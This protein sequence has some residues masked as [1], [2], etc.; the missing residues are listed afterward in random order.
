MGENIDIL[1]KHF[2]D[3]WMEQSEKKGY[4]VFQEDNSPIHT[5]K[6][7]KQ[8]KESIGMVSL[9]WPPNSPDLNPIEHIWYILKITIQKMTPRP[10]TV[11]DMTIALRKAWD[12]LDENTM[13]NLVESM[14]SRIAAVIEAKGRNTKY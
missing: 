11:P 6:L 8:W 2:L 7:A 9:Q 1:E 12:D 3:F 4:I 10:M 13:N 5:C 14:S